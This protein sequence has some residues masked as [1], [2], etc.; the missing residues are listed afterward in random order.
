MLTDISE[1]LRILKALCTIAE[2]KQ[3]QVLLE[4]LQASFGETA[5]FIAHDNNGTT[6]QAY[7]MH[8]YMQCLDDLIFQLRNA[9]DNYVAARQSIGLDATE[10]RDGTNTTASDGI[11]AT[12]DFH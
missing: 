2:S 9:S 12:G 6:A 11:P 10:L 8:G 4:F 5:R 7:K 3:G 1:D